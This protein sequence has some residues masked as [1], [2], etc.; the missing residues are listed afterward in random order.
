VL[1]V[2]DHDQAPPPDSYLIRRTV[3]RGPTLENEMQLAGVDLVE[4][5][6]QRQ[7][8]RAGQ[9]VQLAPASVSGCSG[10][11]NKRPDLHGMA[12]LNC[13]DCA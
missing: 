5:T 3:L 4:V 11:T 8:S 1:R 13:R 9:N 2:R 10:G 6:Q 7:S 12:L